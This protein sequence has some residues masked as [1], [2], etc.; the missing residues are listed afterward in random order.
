VEE[1]NL[2]L[3]QTLS[4]LIKSSFL[5]FI[6]HP[7]VA[8]ED[9]IASSKESIKLSKDIVNL[10]NFDHPQHSVKDWLAQQ[11][12]SEVLQVIAVQVKETSNG[13]EVYLQTSTGQ[14]ST[15]LTNIEGNTVIADIPNAILALANSQDFRLENPVTGI[16]GVTVTQLEDKRLR[17]RVIG[18]DGVPTI[19]VVPN[20]L[21][22]VLSLSSSIPSDIELI[23]TAE[24]TPEDPQ[25]VPISLTVI[26]KEELADGQV[27]SVR[28]IADNT[29]NFYTS[30]GDR[31]FNFQTIRGLGN[32][33]YLVRDAI[34][35]YIDD[36]PYEN[37]HQFLP[38]ELFDLE[39]VEILRGPQGTLYGRNSQAGVVNIISRPPSNKPEFHLGGGYGNFNQRQLQ[40]MLSDAIIPDQLAFRLSGSYNARD[41]FTKDALLGEDANNQSSLYGRANILWTPSPEWSIAF[42]ANAARNEDGDNTFV[43]ID[44]KDPFT[45]TRNIPGILDVSINTQSLKVAYAGSGVN[46][47]SI[48]AHNQTILGYRADTDYTADDLYRSAADIPSTIW[49]QEVRIQ[50]PQT[51][52][53]FR[54]LIGGFYQSRNIDISQYT[55]Y[56]NQGAAL[57]GILP[58]IDRTNGFFEQQT[59]AVFG[60]V[61]VKPI[62]ALTLTAGLRYEKY[63]DEL[64]RDRTF[65]NTDGQKTP[66]GLTLVD[67]VTSGDIVLPRF[68]VQYRFNPVISIYGS[69]ARGYKPATQNYVTEDPSV[70]LVRPEKLWNYELGIKSNWLDNRLTANLAVFWNNIDDYQ[71]LLPDERGFA[72]SIANG[73]VNTHGIEL[74]LRA[75]PLPGFDVIAGF[76]YTNATF[77]QYTNPFTGQ[78]FTGN[79]L[80]YS[81]EYTY[82]LALQYRTP[83]GIFSRLELRGLGTY[84][85][86][87]ANT[88]KQEPFT[89]V[90]TR[91][92]YEGKKYGFYVFVNNIFD[93]R[94]YTTAFKAPDPLVSYGDRRTFGFQL[95]MNF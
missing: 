90:N 55:E 57:F 28:R 72:R 5:L 16:S 32:S 84:F 9:K 12:Q 63:R 73:E 74:E 46:V 58:G 10:Q 53:R 89:L 40:L 19:K 60:Q 41:G 18:V 81:P 71:L 79:R 3:N 15:P 29:P 49:S 61:D 24:K 33:N 59:Y 35:F 48:T 26:P 54:W 87:D 4:I 39:R 83:G 20:S 36:V 94:Y 67:S 80:T 66:F 1:A 92:G 44:Q 85:F 31:S 56:T 8:A 77:G 2:Q 65:E 62:E 91:I 88:L 22:L 42:N 86:D 45:T 34:S 68:A 25:D 14:L 37:V 52:D 47:T 69:I 93:Q 17:V 13:I 70:L 78:N 38:G 95:Q 51:A 6:N 50:S 43:S 11:P 7:D 21:G 76:G 27:N 23:V 64:N 30:V 75:K 82:N